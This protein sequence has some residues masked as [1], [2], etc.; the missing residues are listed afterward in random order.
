MA[1]LVE[2]SEAVFSLAQAGAAGGQQGGE[3][4]S[5]L[6]AGPRASLAFEQERLLDAARTLQA[7][8]AMAGLDEGL[9]SFSLSN[10]L[11]IVNLHSYKKCQ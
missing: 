3:G 5:A 1:S 2:F 11:Y 6:L 7:F 10:L 9:L 4:A 8:P